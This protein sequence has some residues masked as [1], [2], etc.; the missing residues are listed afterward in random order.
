MKVIKNIINSITI[1]KMVESNLVTEGMRMNFADPSAD[2]AF[3][4]GVAKLTRHN[5]EQERVLVMAGEHLYLFGGEKLQRRHRVLKMA[6]FIFSTTSNEVVFCFPEAK[7][8]RF[9]GLTLEEIQQLL[10][11]IKE[12]YHETNPEGTL[13]IFQVTKASLKEYAPEEDRKYNFENF[14]DE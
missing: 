1:R 9:T 3:A 14:P 8:L 7:D 2:V 13:K 6:A 10:A 11:V 12:K 4:R 5:D